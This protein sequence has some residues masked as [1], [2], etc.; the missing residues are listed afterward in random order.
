MS[1]SARVGLY[2]DPEIIVR[3]PGYLEALAEKIGLNWVILTFTG[4]LPPEVLAYS[5]FDSVPP[6]PERVRQLLAYHIDGQ[7]C[8]DDLDVALKSVGPH[9][10]ASNAQK[11]ADMRKAIEM[12]HAA[13]LDCLVLG[14]Y[15]HSP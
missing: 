10:S 13:G 8:T 4:E 15:V 1:K 14:G 2:L 12:C 9:V 6:S 11:D 5:P 3:N 7:P